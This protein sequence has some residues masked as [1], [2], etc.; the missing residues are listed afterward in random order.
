MDVVAPQR[1]E[2]RRD[3]RTLRVRA[4]VPRDLAFFDGHFP[5]HPVLP[6]FVQLHWVAEW[7]RQELGEAPEVASIEALKFREPL[8]PGDEFALEVEADDGLRFRFLRDGESV[9][10]GRLRGG[11]AKGEAP[12]APATD[13]DTSGADLPLRL[14]QQGRMRLVESVLRHADG[15]TL[16]RARLA[17]D[18]PLV[19]EGRAPVWL[20]LELL[21]QGMAAQGGIELAASPSL[22]AFVVGARRVALRARALPV[23]EPLWVRARHVRGE[24]GFVVCDVAVGAGRQA[25]LAHG[26]LTA[27][28]DPDGSATS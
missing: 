16:C 26:R 15:V 8:R 7:A 18:A 17:P 3:G 25:A 13:L 11:S 4:R 5:G 21:A 10:E 9:S 14:P 22:R 2:V 23:G 20:A 19:G 27:F 1:L 12:A 28:V 24:T 6:G